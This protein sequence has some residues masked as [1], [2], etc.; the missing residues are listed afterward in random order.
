MTVSRV[1]SRWVWWDQQKRVLGV[2]APNPPQG[3]G[4][5]RQQFGNSPFGGPDA[6]PRT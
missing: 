3:V 2:L 4:F 1:L 6:A 5:G